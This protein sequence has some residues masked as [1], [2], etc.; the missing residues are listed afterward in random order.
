[1]TPAAWGLTRRLALYGAVLRG[2]PGQGPHLH[3]C[4]A[5]MTPNFHR[6]DMTFIEPWIAKVTPMSFR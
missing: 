6:A 5:R 3:Y 2:R 4:S 1:M